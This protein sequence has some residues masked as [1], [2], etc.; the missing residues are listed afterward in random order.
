MTLLSSGQALGLFG[1][2]AAV[3]VVLFLLRRRARRVVVPSLDA[4]RKDVKSRVNPVWR[5]LIALVL[6]ILAAGLICAFL[7]EDEVAA[8]EAVDASRHVLVVDGS[9][10]MRSA[11]RMEAV[12]ELAR[13]LELGVV[14]ATDEVQVALEPSERDATL[15]RLEAGHGTADLTRAVELARQLGAEPIVVSDHL[16]DIDAEV[17][18]AGEGGAD[19]SIDEVAASAGPG[20]PPEYA[21]R[22]VLTNHGVDPATVTL[23]LETADAL[24]G[25]G[26]VELPGGESVERTYRMDPVAGDWIVA[27]L[28]GH[29]DALPDNDAAFAIL[30]TLRP[31]KV[32]LVSDGNRYLEDV[33]A[34]MPGLQVRRIAPGSYR[35]PPEDVELV[36]FDRV[37]PAG[38]VD[39]AAVFLDPPAQSGPFPPVGAA[40]E[41]EFT[42]W[43]YSHPLLRGV[44]LR[45]LAVERISILSLPRLRGRVI[46]ATDSGPAIVAAD[47]GTKALAIG[48]D[49]RSSDLPL[50][51]AF[52]QLVY[53][54][55][56]WARADADAV[57]PGL[58]RTTTEGV[59]LDPSAGGTVTRLDADGVW[60]VEA[61]TSVLAGLVPGVYE[62]EDR[63]GTRAVALRH[64]PEEHAQFASGEAV[65]RAPETPLDESE[66]GPAGLLALVAF[67][68]LLVEFGVAP[69]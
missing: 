58:A 66:G 1:A 16:V 24:L 64:P 23:S 19:V 15:L 60:V 37:A 68:L 48:F 10:S 14:V 34:V 63:S 51:V 11:G 12:A 49:L 31:A 41:N 65:L 36:F 35:R 69:R 3:L 56:L 61:G 54:I 50:T 17:R 18:I 26:D 21:V 33:L 67:G 6:Q 55:L 4:W 46:A 27:R 22:V 52:P 38:R 5:Q 28:D 8:D 13:A 62:V 43:D 47:D 7:V 53:N 29:S 20:L 59:A 39:A 40:D 9:A 42:T 44:G 57:A 2:C 45:H 25:S 32:W 30:P